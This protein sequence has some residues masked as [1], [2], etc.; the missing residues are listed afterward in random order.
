MLKYFF[1]NLGDRFVRSDRIKNQTSICINCAKPYLTSK[2]SVMARLRRQGQPACSNECRVILR[3]QKL[4]ETYPS[5]FWARVDKTSGHGP[6]NRCWIW[7]KAKDQH[8]YGRCAY[9]GK[10]YLATHI[11][12]KLTH[13]E[14]PKS[15]HLRHSCHNPPCVKPSHLKPGTAKENNSD[16]IEAGRQPLGSQKPEAVLNEEQVV[17]IKQL[18]NKGYL[19]LKIIEELDL[20]VSKAAIGKIKREETWSQVKIALEERPKNGGKLLPS[21]IEE[22]KSLLP[23]M[24]DT[25]IVRHLNLN[26]SSGMV[27]RIRNGKAHLS[28]K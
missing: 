5:R 2:E 7:T 4:K 13:G 10:L 19:Y 24:G 12:Y 11:S 8:G 26:V 20:P 14:F 15:P 21:Q 25:A 16:M 9:E 23:K 27:G 17:K 1:I 3:N 18:L 22:I 6:K 28:Q